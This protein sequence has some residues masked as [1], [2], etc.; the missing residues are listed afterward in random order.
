[1]EKMKKKTAGLVAM[2]VIVAVAMFAGCVEE[3]SY[4]DIEFAS[5]SSV[6]SEILGSNTRLIAEA[7]NN[8][9]LEALEEYAAL[10]Y[11]NNEKA[12]EEIDQFDVSPEMQP[13]KKEYKLGLED[14]KQAA[15]YIERGAKNSDAD[16]LVKGS[17]YMESAT[18]HFNKAAVLML[19]AA[20]K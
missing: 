16:D 15:Y 17:E 8:E 10:Y 18:V 5:W 1:M 3:E 20:N 19:Q 13:A 7:A 2:V 14:S 4:D 6:Q 11:D 9:D 12:L